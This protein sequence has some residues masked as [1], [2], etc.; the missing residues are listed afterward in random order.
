MLFRIQPCC[1]LLVHFYFLILIPLRSSLSFLR[2]IEYLVS[3]IPLFPFYFLP[4][5][6]FIQSFEFLQKEERGIEGEKGRLDEGRGQKTAT[7]KK[8]E[9]RRKTNKRGGKKDCERERN[10]KKAKEEERRKRKG[11]ERKN[12]FIL[13]KSDSS[14]KNILGSRNN[15]I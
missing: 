7:R 11:K 2:S 6:R 14:I 9:E 1:I 12:Y 10:G 3:K 15:N 8:G 13:N 4:V 5:R